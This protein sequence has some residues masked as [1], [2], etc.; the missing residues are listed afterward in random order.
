MSSIQERLDAESVAH[1]H[2]SR[3]LGPFVTLVEQTISLY[4]DAGHA[5]A[6][7]N[8]QGS[9]AKV[10]LI[11]TCRLANDLRACSLLSQLGYGIQA[12]SLGAAIVEIVGALAYVG[13]SESR[14]E[15]WAKHGDI[16]HTYPRW[17]REGIDAALTSLGI[18]TAAAKANWQDAYTFLCTAKHANPRV[19]MLSGLRVDHDGFYYG[20]GPDCSAFGVYMSAGA[21]YYAIGFGMSGICVA[22]IH[23]SDVNLR[24]RLRT[25]ASR[26]LEARHGLE[27]WLGKWR[28]AANSELALGAVSQ[29]QLSAIAA[30]LRS[31]AERLNCKTEQIKQETERIRQGTGDSR[32]D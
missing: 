8:R 21:L 6:E 9:A 17:V 16:R 4:E 10:G 25:E 5:I 22:L 26:V 27:S 23:C 13:D 31:E 1:D 12:S 14:A 30:G 32:R 2:I 29:E 19:S 3:Y 11:L 28:E 20:Y 7:R 18:C 15:E 24:T